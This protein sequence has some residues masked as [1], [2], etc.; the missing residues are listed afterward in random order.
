DGAARRGEAAFM[1]AADGFVLDADGHVLEPADLWE[2]ELPAPMRDR[3]IR[4]RWNPDTQWDERFVEDR[5]LSDRGVAGLGNAGQSYAD[6]GRGMHYED[7]SP[8]GFDP[9]ERVKVLDAEG[10]D[11]AVLYP[12]LGLALGG[13]RAPD[14]AVASCR[15]Y[16]DWIADY[17]AGAPDRLHGVGA[18]P[19]QDLHACLP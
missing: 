11:V 6:Y 9:G 17:A 18:P 7:L 2:R 4:V 15:V 12:G 19:L 14:L 5:M 3:G 10:I 16:N 13:I 8:A 1:T